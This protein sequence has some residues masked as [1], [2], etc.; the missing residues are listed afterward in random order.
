MTVMLNPIIYSNQRSTANANAP[1]VKAM[2]SKLLNAVSFDQPLVGDGTAAITVC[3]VFRR[4]PTSTP[5][6]YFWLFDIWN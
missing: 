5:V 1:S 4:L 3:I 6:L 2:R